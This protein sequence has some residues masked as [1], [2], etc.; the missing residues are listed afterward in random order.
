MTLG[1]QF[2]P[3]HRPNAMTLLAGLVLSL[4]C[5][6]NSAAGV[7]SETDLTQAESLRP[8]F[9]KL[10]TDLVE[11]AKRPD[12]SS[13]DAGCVNSTIRELLQISDEL[14]SYEYLITMQKDLS[15]GGDDNATRGI[16]KFA[17]EKTGSILSAERKRL[18]SL[19]EQCARY[20]VGLGKAQDALKVIDT[21]TDILSSIRERL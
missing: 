2:Y 15:E 20:P 9:G 12:V 5:V 13:G 16:V 17:V 19:S 3:T 8:L 10:M 14:S 7:L 21:T 4:V 1:R 6:G 18:V 11:T